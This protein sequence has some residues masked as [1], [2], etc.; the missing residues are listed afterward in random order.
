MTPRLKNI[1]LYSLIILS[2]SGCAAAGKPQFFT[3]NDMYTNKAIYSQCSTQNTAKVN[4][5]DAIQSLDPENISLL[6]WNIY[7]GKLANWQQD[8][9][10]FIADSDIV[11][12]QEAH[13]SSQLESVLSVHRYQWTLNAAFHLNNQ[14]SGV[15]TASRIQAINTCGLRHK[16]PIIRTH[17]T[18]LINYYPIKG[19]N[20]QLLVANI[21]SINFT[22]GTYAYNK[23]IRHLFNIVNGHE[24]PII[25]AGDFNTWSQSRVEVMRGH[26]K[27]GKLTSL[28]YTKHKRT[29]IF[30][31]AVDHVFYRGLEP[32]SHHS[33]E[34]SSSD[35]NPTRANFRLL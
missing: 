28:D 1:A 27:S 8:L 17:K 5:V 13:L 24:G 16:E 9:H 32:I 18:T 22:L 3:H 21:H 15:M 4:S 33:W 26:V 12:I 7:K 11:T 29:E 25:I 30:G 19:S 20:K 34:V 10:S 31:N 23:Q 2:M 14:P 35:H 6:N